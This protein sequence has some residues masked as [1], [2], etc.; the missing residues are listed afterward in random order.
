MKS[1]INGSQVQKILDN[2]TKT[3]ARNQNI[4]ERETPQR[5]K[6]EKQSSRAATPT[7]RVLHRAKNEEVSISISLKSIS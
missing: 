1:L 6:S 5:A 7:R 3:A 2:V 4:R